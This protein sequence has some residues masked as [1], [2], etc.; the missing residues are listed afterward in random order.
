MG[1][2]GALLLAIDKGLMRLERP[3]AR[4][5][6]RILVGVAV[7]HGRGLARP[8][9]LLVAAVVLQP[10]ECLEPHTL[11]ELG[12]VGVERLGCLLV[13]LV[14]LARAWRRWWRW[15]GWRLRC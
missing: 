13:D 7:G 1:S 9:V 3:A 4:G 8:V 6:R 11:L 10:L 14:L 2:W 15:G 12:L 5:R